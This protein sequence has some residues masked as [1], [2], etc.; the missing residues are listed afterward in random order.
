MRADKTSPVDGTPI[1]PIGKVTRAILLGALFGLCLY[2]RCVSRW[3]YMLDDSAW[4]RPVQ[5]AARGVSDFG[6]GVWA[7]AGLP[8][9]MDLV[10]RVGERVREWVA[11]TPGDPG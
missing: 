7:S 11:D 5:V 6:V 2:P 10:E 1:A 4:S 9:P 3:G 8:V